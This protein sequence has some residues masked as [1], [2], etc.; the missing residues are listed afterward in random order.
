MDPLLQMKLISA[1][2][3][4]IELLMTLTAEVVGS[5][6]NAGN[7]S[8]QVHYTFFKGIMKLQKPQTYSI[9]I[10]VFSCLALKCCIDHFGDVHSLDT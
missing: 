6:T 10:L 5:V 1:H 3:T 4:E 2:Q 7:I 9:I 8:L